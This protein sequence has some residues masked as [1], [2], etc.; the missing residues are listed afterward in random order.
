MKGLVKLSKDRIIKGTCLKCGKVNYF[1]IGEMT[2]EEA[3]TALSKGTSRCETGNHQEVIPP[4]KL[5]EFDWDSDVEAVPMNDDMYKAELIR[6]YGHAYTQ[7]ELEAEYIIESFA[8]GGCLC[9][10]KDN[11]TN[12]K[13]FSFINGPNGTRFYY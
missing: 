7:E 2:K 10:K 13:V 5:F 11:E 12:M 1:N 6:H 9:T 8:F 4:I 3:I